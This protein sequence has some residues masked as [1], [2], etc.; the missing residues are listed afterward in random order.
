MGCGVHDRNGSAVFGGH[1]G[2]GAVGQECRIARTSADLD[3]SDQLVR[4]RV[5]DRDEVVFL[6]CDV[7]EAAVAAGR[8]SLRFSP[9]LELG[10]RA[11]GCDLEHAGLP[12]VLI[13]DIQA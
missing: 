10:E 12:D 6:R 9:D 11:A 2:T 7:D 5:N 8:D 13:C 1:V 4:R 3:L